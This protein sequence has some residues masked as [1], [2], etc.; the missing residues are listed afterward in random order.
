MTPTIVVAVEHDGHEPHARTL[1]LVSL[2]RELAAPLAADITAVVMGAEPAG[3]G[4]VMARYVP[5]VLTAPMGDL[6]DA[7]PELKAR[8]LAEITNALAASIV[9]VPGSKGGLATSSRLA[10]RTGA[11]LFEDV[12]SLRIE[13]DRLHATRL[14]FLSRV[15]QSIEAS[16]DRAVASVKRGVAPTAEPAAEAGAIEAADGIDAAPD[17]RVTVTAREDT[18]GDE[19]TPLEAADVVVTGGRGLGSAEAFERLVLPLAD[20]LGAAVGATRA[21][22][23]SGWRPYAEQVG[24]TGKSVAP[25]V[26]LAIAVSGAVQHLSGM[27]RSHTIVAINKDPDAPIVAQADVSAIGDAHEIVPAL[28][29]ALGSAT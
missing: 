25:R 17:P 26:Y 2:A 27:N 8:A 21:V 3:V 4:E 19:R 6:P 5:R 9:L 20:A 15:E 14:S 28:T 22:V 13:D 16:V 1:E 12:T 11:A 24:Q 7:R 29:E 10:A 18:G 23:D